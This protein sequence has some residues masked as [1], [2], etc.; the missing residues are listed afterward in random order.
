M[1]STSE[2]DL[3]HVQYDRS[4]DISSSTATRGIM[5]SPYCFCTSWCRGIYFYG[6]KYSASCCHFVYSSSITGKLLFSPPMPPKFLPFLL[7]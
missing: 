7:A 1:L 5:G 4:S 2:L 6:Y 3:S